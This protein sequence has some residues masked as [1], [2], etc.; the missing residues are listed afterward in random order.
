MIMSDDQ[1]KKDLKMARKVEERRKFVSSMPISTTDLRDLFNYLD[2]N[3]GDCDHTLIRTISFLEG[4]H[5]DAAPVIE[6]L[7]ENGGYCDCEVI[8]NVEDVFGEL[9][10][11]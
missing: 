10:G 11:K 2:Q 9:V 5:L 6:W 7:R 8:A 3:G 4:R 1:R